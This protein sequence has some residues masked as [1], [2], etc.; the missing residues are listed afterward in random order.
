MP[1]VKAAKK[2]RQHEEVQRQGIQFNRDLGQHI[3]KNPLVVNSLVEKAALRPT[4]VVLEVG[5]GTGNMTVKLM[6]KV[7]KVIACEVDPRLAAELQKRVQGTPIQT[8]LHLIVG[9]VLK[10]ELPFFDVCVANLP[11]QISSPFVFKLLLHRPFFRCAVLMFQREFAQRLVAQPGDK[12]YCRLSI[13]TQLLA[14][15]DHLMKVGKNNFRPPPKVESSVV[16]IEPR[17]PPPSVNFQEWDG[18]VRIAF[19][20]KNKTLSAAFRQ[21]NVLELLEKNY[22]IHCSVNG[23]TIPSDF[24]TKAFIIAILEEGN[25]DKKRPRSMDIDDFLGLLHAFNSRG[26]HFT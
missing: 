19:V 18:L 11:Y 2:S 20:R 5:P 21:S 12:L 23:I 14:R 26:I 9:D 13:N 7:K 22:R 24:D 16:R 3:L 15:V 8:K 1:K 10:S 4:D 25:F 17:N 6:D